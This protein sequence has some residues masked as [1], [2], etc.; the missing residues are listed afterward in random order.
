MA[1]VQVHTSTPVERK[2]SSGP[3]TMLAIILALVIGAALVWYFV[4]YRPSIPT[5][6]APANQG[7]TINVTV[8]PV[9]INTNSGSNP[10]PAPAAGTN[11]G[12]AKP[13]IVA[14]P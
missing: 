13:A 8:P 7:T 10:A 6:D 4:G 3:G 5:T 14:K 1:D 11:T 2:A 9:T 12:G